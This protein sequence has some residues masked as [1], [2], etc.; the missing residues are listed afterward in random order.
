MFCKYCGENNVDGA[1][2]CKNCGKPLMTTSSADGTAAGYNPEMTPGYT[3]T[4]QQNHKKTGIIAIVAIVAAVLIA[5]AVIF[6]IFHAVKGR[7]PEKTIDQLVT[8]LFKLDADGI[9]DTFP[10]EAV[11]KLKEEGNWDDEYDN[12]VSGIESIAQ[13]VGDYVD[14]EELCSYKITETKDATKEEIAEIQ[15]DYDDE[16]IDVKIKDAKIITVELTINIP[17]YGSET[18]SEDFVVIKI[19]NSWYLDPMNF[20]L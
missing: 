19:G 5:V 20:S 7:S 12:L 15:E 2:F 16:G 14:L 10:K 1:K 11:N 17:I 3:P 6:S 9:I 18:D 4:S 13:S 8:S